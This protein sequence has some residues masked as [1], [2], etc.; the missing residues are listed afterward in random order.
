MVRDGFPDQPREREAPEVID[1]VKLECDC[2]AESVGSDAHYPSCAVV[3]FA[4]VD[5]ATGEV[6]DTPQAVIAY[7]IAN[8]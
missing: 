1:L 5:T 4:A 2:G 7:V 8:G 6:L 3:R